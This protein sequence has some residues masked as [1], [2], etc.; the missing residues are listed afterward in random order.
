MIESHICNDEY[1]LDVLQLYLKSPV[2]IKRLYS[3]SVVNLSLD[4]HVSP[5]FIIKKMH[6]I[7]EYKDK[8]PS[9]T[10][11]WNAY[12]YDEKK[13][14]VAVETLKRMRGFG[15]PSKFYK[16]V[17][18]TTSF[19]KM[20]LPISGHKNII[21]AMLVMVLDVYPTIMPTAME[22]DTPEI[23]ELSK[24]LGISKKEV[25][26]IMTTFVLCDPIMNRPK[27]EEDS[28]YKACNEVW[29]EYANDS[30]QKLK[31]KAIE[32]KDYFE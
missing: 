20:F 16:D 26:Q 7:E 22:V 32:L 23:L 30:P 12:A 2:G 6:D 14:G 9:L 21:P 25:L 24:L 8:I 17:T 5:Q 4:L 13:L 28:L 19:E 15:K 10:R 29:R 31:K 18:S 27:D 11:I 1:L 3:R